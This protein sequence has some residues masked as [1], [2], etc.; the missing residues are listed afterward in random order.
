MADIQDLAIVL[1]EVSRRIVGWCVRDTLHA[2]VVRWRSRWPR[3]APL[4]TPRQQHG[5]R[6]PGQSLDYGGVNESLF[7]TLESGALPSTAVGRTP[8]RA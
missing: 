3:R 4:E 7:A 6:P 2:R 8:K 5:T 1:V